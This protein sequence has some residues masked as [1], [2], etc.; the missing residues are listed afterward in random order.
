MDQI[1]IPWIPVEV[2]KGQHMP[3]DGRFLVTTENQTGERK[4]TVCSA[5]QLWAGRKIVAYSPL[6]EPYE[7]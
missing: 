1:S 3:F 7:D 2:E 6:P 4:V 5:R